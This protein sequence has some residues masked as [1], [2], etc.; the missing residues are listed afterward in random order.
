[1]FQNTNHCEYAKAA[2]IWRLLCC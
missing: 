2:R 1:M